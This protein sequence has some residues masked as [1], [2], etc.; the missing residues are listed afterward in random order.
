LSHSTSV[1]IRGM[2]CRNWFFLS[3]IYVV[4]TELRSSGLAVSALP[5]WA[6]LSIQPYMVKQGLSRNL[7]LSILSR[8]AEQ[9]ATRVF[10]S[11][12]LQCWGCVYTPLHLALM[13]VLGVPTEV[14]L[15]KCFTRESSLASAFVC[16]FVCLFVCYAP[17]FNECS[18]GL[19]WHHTHSKHKLQHI[20]WSFIII[21]L[22]PIAYQ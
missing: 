21:S 16:L 2:A 9:Q 11:L 17:A 19:S 10:L 12:P 13:W 14:L 20:F 1:E 5:F 8:E 3:T 7:E 6:I 22:P 15:N 4:S 18:P